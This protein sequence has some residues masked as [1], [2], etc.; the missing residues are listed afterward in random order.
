MIL[1]V[2]ALSLASLLPTSQK[3]HAH[4]GSHNL[5]CGGPQIII[6]GGLPSPFALTARPEATLEIESDATIN[7]K[8]V[9]M[10]A[11]PSIHWGV[12]AL[13]S[14]LARYDVGIAS[15]PDPITVS[16]FASHARGLYELEVTLSSG[17]VELCTIPFRANISGFGAQLPSPPQECQRSAASAPWPVPI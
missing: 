10:P 5:D 4:K 8:G 14:E 3:A 15:G 7:I 12:Q 13:G 16:D 9:D 2:L 17:P 1:L 11:N 6:E